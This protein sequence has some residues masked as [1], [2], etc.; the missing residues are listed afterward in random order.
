MRTT[1]AVA[2]HARQIAPNLRE[3]GMAGQKRYR[4]HYKAGKVGNEVHGK[5]GE[6]LPIGSG[7]FPFKKS[8][9]CVG[10]ASATARSHG[11]LISAK[12]P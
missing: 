7:S 9:I 8:Q 6:D 5:S 10:G 12:G 3:R 1:F 4:D 2:V 11:S